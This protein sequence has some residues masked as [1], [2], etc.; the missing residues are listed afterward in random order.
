MFDEVTGKPLKRSQEGSIELLKTAIRDVDYSVV[1]EPQTRVLVLGETHYSK[2]AKDE[3][4]PAVQKL[5]ELGV[6]HLGMEFI[7]ATEQQV[8]DEYQQSGAHK[9]EI[10]SYFKDNGLQDLYLTLIDAA[11]AAQV[12]VLGI[13]IP[14]EEKERQKNELL[15]SVGKLVDKR[16]PMGSI[17]RVLNAHLNQQGG[18]RD[19]NFAT[20]IK[21]ALQQGSTGKVVVFAG[22][23]HAS[24][25]S[26]SM[27]GILVD[28]GISTKTVS[29][30]AEDE[31]ILKD[32]FLDLTRAADLGGR[33][34]MVPGEIV[35]G[36]TREK[37]LLPRV[38][39]V[40]HV[41]TAR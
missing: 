32:T 4:T 12:K 14:V 6:T 27:A 21:T 23:E 31:F 39:W 18:P 29:L 1:I 16:D 13:D 34:F 24:K 28:W 36:T 2:Q 41:P 11:T 15:G 19:R 38:D 7:P 40:I 37:Q 9:E 25:D 35:S 10:A 30:E 3:V 33:R 22:K 20:V 5:K 17:A 8:V 26:G